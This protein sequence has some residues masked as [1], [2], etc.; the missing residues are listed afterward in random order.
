MAELEPGAGKTMHKGLRTIQCIKKTIRVDL[1]PM[2][3]LGFL[4]ITFFM[5]TTALAQPKAMKL[6]MPAD[7]GETDIPES[8]ALTILLGNHDNVYYY[9]GADAMQLQLTGF[10][11]IRSIINEKK[12]S[13]KPEDFVVVIKASEDANYKNVVDIL[14]E[15]TISEVKRFCLVNISL[16][17]SSLVRFTEMNTG[18]Q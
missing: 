5:F 18:M 12:K 7:E 15:M 1:T 2:V 10:H 4:L 17:E 11:T 6:F 16:A 13:T 8:G 3:D 9:F 14:D